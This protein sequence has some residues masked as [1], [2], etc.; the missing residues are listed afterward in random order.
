MD[1]DIRQNDT[2]FLSCEQLVVRMTFAS[3]DYQNCHQGF[4]P[5]TVQSFAHFLIHCS[6][7]DCLMNSDGLSNNFKIHKL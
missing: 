4:L 3:L 2:S 5:P 1:S 7:L 6:V